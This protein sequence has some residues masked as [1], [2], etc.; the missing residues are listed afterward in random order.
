[1]HSNENESSG[2]EAGAGG[3]E[4]ETKPLQKLW[5]E[6]GTPFNTR[7]RKMIRANK[8]CDIKKKIV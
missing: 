4:K 2:R 8:N 7:S 5:A 6:R 1:M 3:V